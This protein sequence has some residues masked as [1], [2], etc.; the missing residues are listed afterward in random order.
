MSRRRYDMLPD[1]DI[2]RFMRGDRYARRTRRALL[3]A[4]YAARA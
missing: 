1:A 4:R 2:C 3:E